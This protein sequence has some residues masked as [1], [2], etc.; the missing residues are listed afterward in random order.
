MTKT[1][2]KPLAEAI[3]RL[4]EYEAQA[5]HLAAKRYDRDSLREYF[6]KVYPAAASAKGANDNLSRVALQAIDAV[7][8]QPGARFAEG[9]WYQAYNAVT[10]ISDHVQGRTAENRLYSSWYGPNQVRKLSSLKL[11]LDYADKSPDL[12]AA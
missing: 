3:G 12:L 9:S 4:S 5:K 1:A 8:R 7:D 11:A 2:C 10:Y 6:S